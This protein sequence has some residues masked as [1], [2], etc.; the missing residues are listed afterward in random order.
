MTTRA[1]LLKRLKALRKQHRLGEFAL[2]KRDKAEES[3]YVKR[4]NQL[5]KRGSRPIRVRT[6]LQGGP[7]STMVQISGGSSLSNTPS[8]FMSPQ[9]VMRNP[10]TG[11]GSQGFHEYYADWLERQ[12]S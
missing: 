1:A 9:F 2:K 11:T 12:Q 4:I 6:T 5:R 3:G 10:F 7:A 8:S